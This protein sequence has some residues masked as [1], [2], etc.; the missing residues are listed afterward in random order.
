[1]K[2]T[3]SLAVTSAS[4]VAVGDCSISGA[5]LEL[6]KSIVG[7]AD[8]KKVFAATESCEIP[9]ALDMYCKFTSAELGN[10]KIFIS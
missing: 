10:V 5:D 4:A 7:D 8:M 9:V 3:I 6:I 2:P 1:M